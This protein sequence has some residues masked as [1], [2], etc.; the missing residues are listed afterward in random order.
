MIL[1]VRCGFTVSRIW[2]W[3]ET[4]K[5]QTL[6]WE[7]Y[8]LN[9]VL[10]IYLGVPTW[11]EENHIVIYDN[12]VFPLLWGKSLSR[13]LFTGIYLLE[14][15]MLISCPI[16]NK[17]KIASKYEVV[18]SGDDWHQNFNVFFR[19]KFIVVSWVQ[20]CHLE[21]SWKLTFYFINIYV[22]WAICIIFLE[23][24]VARK[25]VERVDH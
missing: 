9:K 13:C 8:F 25:L 21:Y 22:W 11:F 1:V 15:F 18:L 24:E 17:I 7:K 3:N 5:D 16:H 20:Y 23:V 10:L 2:T 6:I 4:T 14:R 19:L 12:H